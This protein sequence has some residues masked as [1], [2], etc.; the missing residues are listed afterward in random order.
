MTIAPLEALARL[1]VALLVGLLIGLDRERAELRK[2]QEEF[3]GVR[4][5]PL[6]ALAGCL[7]LLFPAPYALLLLGV[8][9][10]AVAA[11]T[12]ISYVHM[13]RANDVG[14]T[15]EIAAIATFLI[16]ALA[17]VGALRAA[18]AAGVVVAILLVAKPRL[19]GFSRAL[20]QEELAAVLELAVISV[21]VLPLVPDRG[22]GPWGVLNPRDIWWVVVLVAGLS[23]AGFVAVRVVGEQRG[24]TITGAI[25]GLVSSTAVTVAM[26]DRSRET[27]ALA[28]PAAAATVLASTIMAVRVAVLGA[29]IDAGVLARLAP[30]AAAMALAGAVAARQIARQRSGDGVSAASRLQNPF[31]LRQA[32]TFALIYGGIVLAVRAAQEYLDPSMIFAVAAIS[33]VADVDAATIAF[34]KLGPGADAWRT[35]AAA[36]AVAAV[37]NTLV[38]LGIAWARGGGAYRRFVAI[39]LGAMAAAGAAVGVIVFLR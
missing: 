6:I 17:G 31:S 36:I 25:G 38:K 32:V 2:G 12:V 16:G 23:F 30:V 7:P 20:T 28:R 33:A 35:P 14:A 8:S 27:D 4:T 22:Y 18:A 10:A 9:F 21:I 29:I 1:G 39:A 13:T 24:L 11:V 3:A 5:F 26:A 37:V 34:T 19:E 15:T